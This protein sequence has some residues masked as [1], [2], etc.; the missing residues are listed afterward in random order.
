MANPGDG[1]SAEARRT[2]RSA[3]WSLLHRADLGLAVVMLIF[4]GG[5][6][7]VTTTFDE[8]S[9]L[10]GEQIPPE[11]FPRLMI[12]SIAVLSLALP[13]EH[14]FHAEGRKRLDQDRQNRIQPIT[15]ITA[16]LLLGVVIAIELIG[17]LLAMVLACALMPPLWGE[18]RLKVLVPYALLFPAAVAIL[19]S[20]VLKIYFEPGLIGPALG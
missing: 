6:Y 9:A 19:F 12:W 2:E 11:W 1:T 7:Y 20:Q 16:A 15:L 13:F 4:C 5:A 3:A 8:P 10:F 18:R 14:L 17:T